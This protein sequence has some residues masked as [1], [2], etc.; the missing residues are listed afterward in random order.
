M[1]A[2]GKILAISLAAFLASTAFI[3][4]ASAA[5]TKIGK[6]AFG[7]WKD[8][9]PGVRRHIRAPDL[10]PPDLR[11]EVLANFPGEAEKPAE[12][13]P[14]VL[15]G[16]TVEMVATGIESPRAMRFAPNGDLFVADS[17]IG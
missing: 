10:P 17:G 7:D 12:A 1:F 9:K 6:A 15:E 14:Q 11:E 2:F 3:V 4:P 13:K 5:E 8:D 16:F